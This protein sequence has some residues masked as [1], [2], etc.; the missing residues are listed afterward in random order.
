MHGSQGHDMKWLD[1]R[2]LMAG[3]MTAIMLILKVSDSKPERPNFLGTI[4]PALL[5]AWQPSLFFAHHSRLYQAI[6]DSVLLA[7]LRFALSCARCTTRAI[8]CCALQS[9]EAL[10]LHEACYHLENWN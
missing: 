10:D 2:G 4:A 6:I 7:T 3:G 8:F 1:T 9:M 5:L